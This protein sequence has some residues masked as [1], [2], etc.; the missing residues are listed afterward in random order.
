MIEQRKSGGPG[1]AGR[2][3]S[4]HIAE[5]PCRE[6]RADRGDEDARDSRGDERR[7]QGEKERT[8]RRGGSRPGQGPPHRT[9]ARRRQKG[10]PS[11][12]LEA[13]EATTQPII[14]ALD[15]PFHF[16]P[17]KLIRTVT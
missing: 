8:G 7:G 4:P 10:M 2:L 17:R 6:G 1:A 12:R 3:A 15:H 16:D 14:D 5:R 9:S 11:A 13:I